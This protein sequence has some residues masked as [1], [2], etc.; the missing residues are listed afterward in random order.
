MK[1]LKFDSML[2]KIIIT[3]VLASFIPLKGIFITLF[4]YLTGISIAIL[5][6]MHGAKLSHKK[7]ILGSNNWKLHIWIMCSTFIIFPFLGLILVWYDPLSVSSE[8]NNGFLYLCS[9]PAT[10]QSAI[11][12]TSIAEGNV[13]AS[14]CSASASSLLGIFI[15]PLIINLI[16]GLHINIINIDKEIQQIAKIILQLFIP[17]LLGHISRYWISQWIDQNSNLINK[18]DQISI[19]FVVYSAFSKAVTNGIWCQ[20]SAFTILW[21]AIQCTILLFFVLMINYFA[22]KLLNFNRQDEIVVLFCGSKKSLANGIP[23]ANVLFPTSTV[24]I[25]ILPLM[26]FHQVQL[27]VCSYIAQC[28][29]RNNKI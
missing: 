2:F 17:F 16:L 23:M 27:M 9:M 18:I 29:K 1:F 6:F 28:Y 25:I 13:A 26:I 4:K 12:F 14:I 7:I 15:S 21:I 19:L 11:A 8:I 22:A 24:G 10:V 20:V 5:F 3:V